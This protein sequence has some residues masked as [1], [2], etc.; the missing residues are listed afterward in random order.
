M[1]NNILLE[2]DIEQAF[3]SVKIV[4]QMSK[5]DKRFG[6]NYT[7]DNFIKTMSL[8]TP[9]AYGTRLESYIIEKFGLKRISSTKG[10]GDF[11]DTFCN[12]YEL[13]ISLLTETNENLNLVQIRTWQDVQGYLCIAIDTRET[14][15]KLY[16]FQL[17]KQ[18]MIDELSIMN[19]TSAHGTKKA[20]TSNQNVELRT[21]ILIKDGDKNFCRWKNKY[22]NIELS[23][24]FIDNHTK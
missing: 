23:D 5:N 10:L 24:K 8:L 17:T 20:N 1:T 21:S 11:E 18:Q 4:K 6:F 13:K 9:Q 14:P 22:L 7:F 12:K 15:I 19:A 2:K 16:A 3:N